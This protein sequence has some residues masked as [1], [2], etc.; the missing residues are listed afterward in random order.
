MPGS[1]L[2]V[3]VLRAI[4]S[5]GLAMSGAKLFFFVTGTLTPANTYT[6]VGLSTPN[7]NP[8]VADSGGLFP[9]IYMDPS[10]TYRVQLKDSAGSL[11]ADVD[12]YTVAA[13]IPAGGVTGAMLAAGAAA[14]NIG[15]TPAND[16]A[17]LK[18]GLRNQ[19]INAS[20]MVPRAT[21]GA[22]ATTVESTTNKVLT[23]SLDFDQS[24]AQY[25]QIS[26]PLPKSV[27]AATM[28]AR[29]RWTAAAGTAGQVVIWGA[30]L[31]ALS[32]GDT[33]DTAFGTAQTVSDT[34]IATGD[35]HITTVTAAITAGN[36]LTK[37]DQLILQVYRDAANASD[38]LA[39]SAKLVSVEIF[40]SLDAATDT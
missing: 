14:S 1:L 15:F 34:L 5:A 36:G 26:I 8:V 21:N 2:P 32:D 39:A 12:P 11:I 24:T 31:L 10:I 40:L 29:F 4:D 6:T 3:L 25:A 7:T 17:V 16:T 38:T 20:A 23:A 27:A 33:I 9:V 30:Q 18:Q 19:V 13:N 35:F 37:Q 22:V 28:T